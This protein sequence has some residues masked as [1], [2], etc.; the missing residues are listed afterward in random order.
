MSGSDGRL[1][2]ISR[3]RCV[4]THLAAEPFSFLFVKDLLL[5]LLLLILGRFQ[6]NRVDLRMLHE[7]RF[8][9]FLEQRCTRW[10]KG[11]SEGGNSFAELR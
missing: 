2:G 4:N 1:G 6:R 9:M 5:L 3:D 7:N 10:A 8:S 11:Q